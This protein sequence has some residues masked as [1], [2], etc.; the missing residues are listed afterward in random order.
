M[1]NFENYGDL[2]TAIAYKAGHGNLSQ[3]GD[4]KETEIGRCINQVARLIDQ[5]TNG[6]YRQVKAYFRTGASVSADTGAEI[7]NGETTV[8]FATEIAAAD[9]VGKDIVVGGDSLPYAIVKYTDTQTLEVYPAF[10][11]DTVVNGS[12]VIL[13]G[14]LRMPTD[15]GS[16]LSLIDMTNDRRVQ[17]ISLEKC[18]RQMGNPYLTTTNRPTAYAHDHRLELTDDPGAGAEERPYRLLLAPMPTAD[19][20]LMMD[21]FRIATEMSAATD[22]PDIPAEHRMTLLHGAFLIYAEQAL[23]WD[24]DSL[25]I[26]RSLFY[27]GLKA[28]E[29]QRKTVGAA[30]RFGSYL[31]TPAVSWIEIEDRDIYADMGWPD[32]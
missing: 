25:K 10:T 14:H 32:A 16:I 27:E 29:T 28:L 3:A 30:T 20:N 1:S 21:Y 6:R 8:T 22:T 18:R 31:Q 26:T 2:K 5:R 17:E 19:V 15:F 4:E 11:G 7:T 23:R 13:S 12:Y 9:M 24:P